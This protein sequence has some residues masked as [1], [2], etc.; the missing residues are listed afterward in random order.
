MRT[1]TIYKLVCND[2]NAA[3]CYVGS[4]DS[5]RNRKNLHKSVCNNLNAKCYYLRVY[6]YIR[7]NGGWEN[8]CL[9]EIEQYEY[10]RKPQLHARERYHMEMLGATLNSNVPHRTRAERCQDNAEQMRQCGKQ[11]REDNSLKI[12]QYQQD[13]VEHIKQQKNEKHDCECGSKYT[14]GHKA[15]HLKTQRHCLYQLGLEQN[16]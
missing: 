13:N 6:K 5:V 15:R 8:W 7:E 9:I 2:L 1:G 16:V 12:K 3:E 10:E 11:Y 14:N 4:T